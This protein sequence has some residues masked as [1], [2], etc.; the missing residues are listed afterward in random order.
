MRKLKLSAKDLKLRQSTIGFKL[1][2]SV[3]DLKPKPSVRKSRK[4][5]LLSVYVSKKR[6]LRGSEWLRKRG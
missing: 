1:R 3:R 2:P 6:K 4:K 5:K